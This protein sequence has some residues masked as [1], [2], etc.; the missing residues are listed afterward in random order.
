MMTG[1]VIKAEDPEV[2]RGQLLQYYDPEI[3]DPRD[4]RRTGYTK[5][6]HDPLMAIVYRTGQD[7]MAEWMRV[8]VAVPL[9]P[10]G[11]PN[12]PLSAF[13]ITIMPL[14]KALSEAMERRG[15]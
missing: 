4:P 13:T 1:F 2:V 6:T 10:D 3:K 5:W 14:E 8:S 15:E 7:A 12:R 11:R 9:R